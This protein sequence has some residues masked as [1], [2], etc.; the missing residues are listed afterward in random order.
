MIRLSLFFLGQAVVAVVA[1]T[2]MGG[3]DAHIVLA[4]VVSVFWPVQVFTPQPVD[5]IPG[6]SCSLDSEAASGSSAV[7][8]G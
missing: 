6:R 8:G 2:L 3:L 4:M 5:S 1:W 7:G